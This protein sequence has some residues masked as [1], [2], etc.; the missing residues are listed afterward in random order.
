MGFSLKT[1][2]NWFFLYYRATGPTT[3]GSSSP[4][5]MVRKLKKRLIE[6]PNHQAVSPVWAG[7]SSLGYSRKESQNEFQLLHQGT[8]L[9]DMIDSS[10]LI[11]SG[12]A[13]LAEYLSTDGASFY[14]KS[15]GP[16]EYRIS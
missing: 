4:Q 11:H 12:R 13:P 1:Q 16:S 7:S 9:P 8:A 6:L 15:W 3:W 2:Q 14:T 10:T 5:F